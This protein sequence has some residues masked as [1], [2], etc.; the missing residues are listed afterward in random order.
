MSAQGNDAASQ[1]G[2]LT[3]Y[4][5]GACPLCRA[6]LSHYTRRDTAGHLALVDVSQPGARLPD[7]LDPEAAKARF[8]VMT[9][10][11]DLASGAAAFA[12][13]WSRVPGWRLA[14]RVARLPGALP[15]L[16]LVY[17]GFL[18]V[19]P[20]MVGIFVRARRLRGKVRG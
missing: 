14:A 19:R 13:V 3:V 11:G 7:G 2:P 5:D 15:V 20:Q 9:P 16:E 17:K 1:A 4:Y 8:H 10:G 18:R 6:E 12:E